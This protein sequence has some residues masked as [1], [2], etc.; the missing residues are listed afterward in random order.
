M[1][2]ENLFIE[3]LLRLTTPDR[4]KYYTPDD[5]KKI[6]VSYAKQKCAEQRE[7]CADTYLTTNGAI[8]SGDNDSHWNIINNSNSPKFIDDICP[9]CN[10]P[11]GNSIVNGLCAKCNNDNFDG[12]I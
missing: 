1:D 7:I 3:D 11:F 2:E 5:V 10:M 6:C 8:V 4:G 9:Q 12:E